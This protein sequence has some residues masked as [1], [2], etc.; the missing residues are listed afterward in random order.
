MIDKVINHILGCPACITSVLIVLSVF[1]IAIIYI[2]KAVRVTSTK[3]T[4]THYDDRYADF[5]KSHIFLFHTKFSML[6][7]KIRGTYSLAH[8]YII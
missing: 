5:I 8:Y 3:R 7:N 1:V 6:G 4:R 2:I